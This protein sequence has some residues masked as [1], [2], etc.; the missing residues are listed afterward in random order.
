M[1][2]LAIPVPDPATIAIISSRVAR[3]GTGMAQITRRILERYGTGL[4]KKDS[5]LVPFFQLF[6]KRSFYGFLGADA[7]GTQF[8]FQR[9]FNRAAWL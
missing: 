9:F 2:S 3:W 1:K 4:A 6:R 7:Q 5:R 8:F